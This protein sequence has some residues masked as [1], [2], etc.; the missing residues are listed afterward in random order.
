ML[1]RIAQFPKKTA[2]ENVKEIDAILLRKENAKKLPSKQSKCRRNLKKNV[3][4][5][6]EFAGQKRL[7]KKL[8]EDF[9]Q[10]N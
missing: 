9:A 3:D 6:N 5:L 8:P 10:I 7:S 2:V 4:K 1:N